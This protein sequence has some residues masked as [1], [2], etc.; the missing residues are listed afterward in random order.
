VLNK[1]FS[2]IKEETLK[3]LPAII[4]FF[5]AFSLIELTF[6][7]MLE[8]AGVHPVPFLETLIASLLIGKVLI[9][10]DH[11]PT[12]KV[13]SDKPIIYSA[14]FKTAVYSFACFMLRS[15]EHMIRYYSKYKSWSAA[16]HHSTT[17]EAAQVFI[18]IQIWYFLLFF[19][20]VSAREL[21]KRIGQKEFRKMYFG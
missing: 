6:G 5:V 18:S 20:F 3:V 10:V 9:I 4:Y 16:W 17:G 2:T 12:A 13:A 11:M 21:I 15:G 1:I 14:L 8:H 19:I 7:R